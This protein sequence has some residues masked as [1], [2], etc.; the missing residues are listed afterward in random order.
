VSTRIAARVG[1]SPATVDARRVR[2]AAERLKAF[3]G[4]QPGRGRKP[5]IS[6]EKVAEIVLGTLHE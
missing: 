5:S 4:V 3:A 1:V 6:A 2:F